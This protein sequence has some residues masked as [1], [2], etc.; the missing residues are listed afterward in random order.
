MDARLK[1]VEHGITATGTNQLVVGSVLNEATAFDGD[2]RVCTR[3]A[4]LETEYHVSKKTNLIAKLRAIY[5]YSATI[6]LARTVGGLRHCKLKDIVE[7][8]KVVE[9]K[10]EPK[11]PPFE[12]SCS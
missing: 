5:T 6:A 7:L 10:T 1:P 4:N 9:G 8:C 11:R 2:P 3:K 12:F